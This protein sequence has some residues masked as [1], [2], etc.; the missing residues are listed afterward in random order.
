MVNGTRTT[1]NEEL[2]TGKRRTGNEE[3][4]TRNRTERANSRNRVIGKVRSM[5][6]SYNSYGVPSLH[7]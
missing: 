7:K 6:T 1:E 2:R 4:E 5:V 3:R